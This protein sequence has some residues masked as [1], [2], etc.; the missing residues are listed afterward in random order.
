MPLST[1]IETP[2]G[3]IAVV[4]DQ[5]AISRIKWAEQ[6]ANDR[7]SLLYEATRQLQAYFGGKL[8]EFDLPFH[9]Q[10]SRFQRI[11][12]EAMLEIPFGQTE[13]YGE[14]AA[15]IGSA[16][17]PVGNACGGNPFPVVVPCHRVLGSRDLGGYSGEGGIETKIT[18]LR[19]ENA[20]PRLI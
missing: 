18:L 9:W 12:C 20:I 17:Q 16:A 14:L 13:T 11:V 7:S 3:L 6:P 4:E 5:E 8:I 2:V 15:R 1:T 10:C 19:H